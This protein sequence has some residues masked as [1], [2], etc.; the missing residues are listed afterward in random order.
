MSQK[1]NLR[2]FQNEN[3]T[4]FVS[5]QKEEASGSTSIPVSDLKVILSLA[6]E[7]YLKMIDSALPSAATCLT[8]EPESTATKNSGMD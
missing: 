6:R 7:Q 3:Q 4:L 8:D 2:C 1:L 5:G